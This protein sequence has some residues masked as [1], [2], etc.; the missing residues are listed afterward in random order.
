MAKRFRDIL[1]DLLSIS[2]SQEL[3]EAET[4]EIPVNSP[5]QNTLANQQQ[6]LQDQLIKTM[7]K[8]MITYF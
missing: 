3:L 1:R 5:R 6:L 4:S 8:T 2:K 7:T